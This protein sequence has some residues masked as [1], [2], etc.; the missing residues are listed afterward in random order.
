[1]S[2]LQ[3]GPDMDQVAA[4]AIILAVITNTL[5]KGG[6]AAVVGDRAYGT[7]VL[8]TAALAV[9]AG[10]LAMLGAMQTGFV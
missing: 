8:L 2:R 4:R 1:M 9:S 10:L 6:L 5:F 7:R 3:D